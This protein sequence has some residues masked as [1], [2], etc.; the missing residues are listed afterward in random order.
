MDKGGNEV[1]RPHTGRSYYLHTL[2]AHC[3]CRQ[4]AIDLPHVIHSDLATLN[5]IN[6]ASRCSNQH[7]TSARQVLH[8][9]AN[10]GAAVHDT[11]TYVRSVRK[12]H[13]TH[14]QHNHCMQ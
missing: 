5:H 6:E 9:G 7:M 12:L 8:L 11:S 2:M 13:H 14:T 10:V 3:N 4:S 1:P